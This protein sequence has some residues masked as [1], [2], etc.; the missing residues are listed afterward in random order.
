[1][2]HLV[3]LSRR[4]FIT[5][6]LSAAGG[7][8]IGLALPGRADA[9]AIDAA[10]WASI[11][12]V[13][14]AEINAWI[15]IEPDDSVTIRVAQSEM[16]EGIFTALPMIVAE[17]LECDWTKVRA[18]Y[19]EAHRN[20]V[21]GHPYGRMGTGGSGAVRRSREFLQQAGASA[22]VRLI[23]AAAQQWAVPAGDC[24]ARDGKVTH[25]AS[26][27]WLGYGAL[28]GAAAKIALAEEP[29]IKT[30]DQFRL[31]GQPQARFDTPVKVN[32]QAKFGI[33]TRIDGMVYAAV[34]TCPVFGGTVRHVDDSKVRGRR[35]IR[36]I[37]PIPGGIAVV[38]DSFWR[39]KQAVAD[40][41]ITWDEG[42]GAGT[43][44]D[45]FR[46]EYRDTLDGPAANAKHA[47]DVTAALAKAAKKVDALYEAPHVAHAAMEPLNATVHIQGDRLDA[48]MGTQDP[49]GALQRAAKAAGMKP[50][51]VFIHNCFLGGG[52]GR[53]AIND[54]LEQ[55]VIVAKAVGK[56]VKLVWTREE[57]MQHDRY[58][59][60]AAIRFKAGLGTDGMPV[61]WDMRT[62]VGSISRSL[63]RDPVASGV[64]PSAVE[65]LS[66]VPY[67]VANLNVDCILKNTHVPVMFWRSVGSSQ[68]AFALE[69]F[70][71]EM[72]VAAGKD[73]YRFR[74]E[75]LAGKPD[76]LKVLDT[77]AEKGDWSKKLP[78]GQ[79]RGIA[80]HESF[81][82]IV[83]EIVE[84]SVSPKG[85]V[86]VPRVVAVVDCGHVVNPRTV[87]MQ[88]ESAVIYG[89]TAALYGEITI[90]DGRVQEANFDAYEM[91]RFADAP[92]IETYLALSGGTK[93]GGI[94]EPGTP[95][96]APALCNA[97]FAATGKRIR[98]LP[99][100]NTDLSG[101][102]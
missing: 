30:P 32:G 38:A 47:G 97:I 39:A 102:A 58:R 72:A 18:E 89:L 15:L 67:A 23:A 78:A 56:P 37:V 45:Q 34:T 25:A 70:V 71:D 13:K 83:G 54:E 6:G 90:K 5:S 60:Q 11:T 10:P 94:G 69:S 92:V 63:G 80:I 61:A 55:A 46:K 87:E 57:D 98:S 79:G 19:A 7:L 86:K 93:W 12:D 8:A 14:A 22:R 2:T 62:A 27:R 17:E 84:V 43:D 101:R 91:V 41:V 28:A 66:N 26:Q 75:L 50:E 52:F 95:P 51:Q 76:F 48:W 82:T 1:M 21:D 31:I 24:S 73:P 65:G 99:I 44:S 85:E 33:D 59:P 100:K 68:N 40:L 36:Q 49:D 88:I 81:G 9:L 35:G 96:I 16:G 42:A 74:R 20:L 53:R 3:P 64:E 4:F 77:L 29:A